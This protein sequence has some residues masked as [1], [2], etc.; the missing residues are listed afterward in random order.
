VVGFTI[1]P[2]WVDVVD[3]PVLTL[4]FFGADYTYWFEELFGVVACFAPFL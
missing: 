4:E 2:C 1:W 3:G